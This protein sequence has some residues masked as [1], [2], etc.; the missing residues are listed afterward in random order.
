MNEREVIVSAGV[1][2]G[3]ITIFGIRYN[4]GWRFQ[5]NVVDQ[6]PLML[7]EKE[8][9]HDSAWASSWEE[10][11]TLLDRYPWH[12]FSPIRVHPEFRQAVWAAVQKRCAGKEAAVDLKQ[13][14][15]RCG[16]GA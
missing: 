10:A 5:R 6:S 1:G 14:R 11:L 3:A 12:R 4:D 8:I 9:R 2:S 15:G 16:I 13:W 7:D